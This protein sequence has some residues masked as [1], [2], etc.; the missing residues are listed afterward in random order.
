VLC[1]PA[2]MRGLELF[3]PGLTHTGIRASSCMETFLL[4][5]DDPPLCHL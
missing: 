2:V 3:R 5:T 1:E 4:S